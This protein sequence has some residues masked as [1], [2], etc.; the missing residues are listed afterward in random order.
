MCYFPLNNLTK[1]QAKNSDSSLLGCTRIRRK[2]RRILLYLVIM[3]SMEEAATRNERHV[4]FLSVKQRE[5]VRRNQE[6]Y[7][8]DQQRVLAH[9]QG[10]LACI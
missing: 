1:Y 2:I 8:L 7:A 10:N 9:E 5:F 4:Q 6:I 3:F